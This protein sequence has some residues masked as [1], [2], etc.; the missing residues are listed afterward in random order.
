MF[1]RSPCRRMWA[2]EA[3][4]RTPALSLMTKQRSSAVSLHVLDENVCK[5]ACEP[6]LYTVL[7]RRAVLYCTAYFALLRTESTPSIYYA[8]R[9]PL[10]DKQVRGAAKTNASSRSR[11]PRTP[12]SPP[13]SRT[14]RSVSQ[15]S[16]LLIDPFPRL[17]CHG[18]LGHRLV[19]T[20][21]RTADPGEGRSGPPVLRH[22]HSSSPAQLELGGL[23]RHPCIL[24]QSRLC[25]VLLVLKI[26]AELPQGHGLPQRVRY[27][28]CVFAGSG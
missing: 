5:G 28:A 21:H 13:W 12:K 11:W 8:K 15:T 6:V 1:F 26:E 14:P 17:L 25:N 24:Q 3:V 18:A 22:K 23:V 4:E 27:L 7:L 9:S 19:T 20:T 10:P 2:K 16:Q